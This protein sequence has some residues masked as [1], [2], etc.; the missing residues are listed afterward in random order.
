MT[1]VP[2]RGVG[3]WTHVNVDNGNILPRVQTAKDIPGMGNLGEWGGKAKG[4][5]DAGKRG[6]TGTL[7]LSGKMKRREE[8]RDTKKKRR[9]KRKKKKKKPVRGLKA[10]K[11]KH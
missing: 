1:N 11:K 3:P 7:V 2:K 8:D 5:R 4:G 10:M 6:P 9:I